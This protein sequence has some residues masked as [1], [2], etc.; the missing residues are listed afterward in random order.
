MD[1]IIKTFARASEAEYNEGMRWYQSAHTFA[2]SLCPDIR[3]A[4]GVIAALSPRQQWEVNKKGAEKVFRAISNHSSIVPSVAGTYLNVEKAWRIANG[5]DPEVVLISSDPKR[6]FKV[7]RFFSNIVGN[8]DVVTVDT[9]TAMAALDNPPDSI[10]G[11]CYLEIEKRFQKI[12]GRLKLPP[13]ELQAI[14]W[15][16]VRN[17]GK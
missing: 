13:R 7:R 8:Q 15:T 12:A 14:C 6:Y 9:W 1:K 4:A 10:R 2:L 11:I 5:E 16:V 3:K 17:H